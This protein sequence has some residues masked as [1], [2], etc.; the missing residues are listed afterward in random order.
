MFENL[1]YNNFFLKLVLRV[2]MFF[3]YFNF[4]HEEPALEII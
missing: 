2:L 4:C 1:I 3:S